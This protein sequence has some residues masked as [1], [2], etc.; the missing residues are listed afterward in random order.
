MKRLQLLMKV[1]VVVGLVMMKV[2]LVILKVMAMVGLVMMKINVIILMMMMVV[3][4]A[5]F[6][7]LYTF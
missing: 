3:V 2:R 7:R 1:M 6:K 4:D 5:F